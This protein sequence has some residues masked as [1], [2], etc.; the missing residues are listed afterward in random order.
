MDTA[1]KK[2]SLKHQ[3]NNVKGL[4]LDNVNFGATSDLSNVDLSGVKSM[5]MVKIIGG[6]LEKSLLV[7][8]PLMHSNLEG[9]NL[10][11][12]DLSGANISHSNLKQVNLH[13]A[14]LSKSVCVGTDFT[15]ATNM[16]TSTISH[17]DFTD[18]KLVNVVLSGID[19]R[20]STIKGADF[21]LSNLSDCK[22]LTKDQDLTG[23]NFIGTI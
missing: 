7:E 12:T 11:E 5:N 15:Q 10:T 3:L 19:L 22:I 16:S 21:N 13:N 20:T 8:L 1:A 23:V 17:T 14:N 2:I 6:T 18:A 4:S 9:S